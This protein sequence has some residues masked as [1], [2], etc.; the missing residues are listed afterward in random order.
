MIILAKIDFKHDLEIGQPVLVKIPDA[1][2]LSSQFENKIYTIHKIA[3]N[4]I[5]AIA[6]SDGRPL[7]YLYRRDRLKPVSRFSAPLL[8]APDKA[9]TLSWGGVCEKLTK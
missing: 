4:H 9:P 7:K 1:P 6:D 8:S 2:K 3:G 5:Y